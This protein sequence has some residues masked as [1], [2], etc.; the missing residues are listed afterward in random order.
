MKR[1]VCC[2]G[3]LARAQVRPLHTS[4]ALRLA[5]VGLMKRHSI[6]CIGSLARA[7]VR[8]LHTS[9]ALRLAPVGLMKRHS[10]CCIGS[11]ARAQVRPLHTSGALRLAPVGDYLQSTVPLKC[12]P[13]LGEIKG[14][15]S[16]AERSKSSMPIKS[17]NQGISLLVLKRMCFLR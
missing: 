6:C 11:L 9:G 10:I 12:V 4:G 17:I 5:P 7:Q 3:S 16:S 8:P 14:I 1:P 2:I 13:I 15:P